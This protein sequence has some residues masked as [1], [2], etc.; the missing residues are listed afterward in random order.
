M[1]LFGTLAFLLHEESTMSDHNTHPP[2]EYNPASD[3]QRFMHWSKYVIVGCA[4]IVIALRLL[5]G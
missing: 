4:V 5:I 2:E 3:Y 1:I